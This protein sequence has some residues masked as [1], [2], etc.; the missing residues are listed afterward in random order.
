MNERWESQS[1]FC[2]G[3]RTRKEGRRGF[4]ALMDPPAEI[5]QNSKRPSKAGQSSP[6]RTE[7]VEGHRWRSES[8]IRKKGGSPKRSEEV[9]VMGGGDR[10]VL[11]SAPAP[12]QLLH[13]LWCDLLQE[14]D[15]LVGVEPR[16]LIS[17][18]PCRTLKVEKDRKGRGNEGTNSV[19]RALTLRRQWKN[20]RRRPSCRADRSW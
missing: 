14:I 7:E 9:V 13:S 12:G 15:V 10:R 11:T 16:K 5:A 2:A 18:G 19:E 17:R 8:R 3:R 6:V 20:V 4:D 1:R